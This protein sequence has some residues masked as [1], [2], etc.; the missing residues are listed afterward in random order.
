ME[1][2]ACSELAGASLLSFVL[3][4]EAEVVAGIIELV[5][6]ML[7]DGLGGSVEGTIIGEQRAIDRVRLKFGL[8]LQST[9]VDNDAD[10]N[11]HA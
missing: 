4:V 1:S 10:S 2:K 11:V 9:E 6:A 8:C 3:R 5:N 7:H